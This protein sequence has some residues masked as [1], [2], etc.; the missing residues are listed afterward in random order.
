MVM[1]F[2]N[3]ITGKEW[4]AAGKRPLQTAMMQM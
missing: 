1:R 2:L 4:K 3:V